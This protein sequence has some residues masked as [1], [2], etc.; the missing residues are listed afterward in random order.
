MTTPKEIADHVVLTRDGAPHHLRYRLE[1]GELIPLWRGC[2][3]EKDYLLEH[4]KPWERLQIVMLA[5]ILAIGR[6]RSSV[7]VGAAATALHEVPRTAGVYDIHVV[8]T[9]P[10][11]AGRTMTFPAVDLGDER[12]A[13]CR[14]VA[15]AWRLGHAQVESIRG[16][17]VLGL[18]DA[19]ISELLLQDNENGF[20]AACGGL[21]RISKFHRGAL[22]ESRIREEKYRDQLLERLAGWPP[23]MRG[24]KRARWALL[25]ADAACESVAEGRL[26][27]ILRRAGIAVKSQYHVAYPGGNFYLDFAIPEELLAIEFDGAIKYQGLDRD[28]V[29]G[30]QLYREHLLR[31][32]GWRVVRF[33]WS[34]LA[35]PEKVLAKIM[36]RRAG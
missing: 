3:L 8:H 11:P 4:K 26:L 21:R 9:A 1:K 17:Q 12:I 24:R 15:H 7:L 22:D 16:V 23:G 34:D 36:H 33:K 5:R 30:D 29:I 6:R 25:N 27:Y 2:Y 18:E 20:V 31:E 32:R 13:S 28:L 14:V 10:R 35:A 19:V